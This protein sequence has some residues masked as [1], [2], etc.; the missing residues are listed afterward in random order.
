MNPSSL[1][2]NAAIKVREFHQ[3]KNNVVKN[4]RE[5]ISVLIANNFIGPLP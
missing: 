1:Q 3:K 4:K 2:H 5:N